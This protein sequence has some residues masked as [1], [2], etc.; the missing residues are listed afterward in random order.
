MY[1]LLS[2]TSSKL[3]FPQLFPSFSEPSDDFFLRTQSYGSAALCHKAAGF[4]KMSLGFF[5]HFIVSH[6]KCPF[7]GSIADSGDTGNAG[8]GET[9]DVL[10]RDTPASCSCFDRLRTNGGR[11]SGKEVNENE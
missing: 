2:R 6:M 10:E 4:C 11:T 5:P 3:S 8:I 1:S 7:R 9:G